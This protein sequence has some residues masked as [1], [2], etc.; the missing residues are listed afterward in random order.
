[1]QRLQSKEALRE[2]SRGVQVTRRLAGFVDLQS[3]LSL[4]S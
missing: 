2:S 4:E 3:S 1:M